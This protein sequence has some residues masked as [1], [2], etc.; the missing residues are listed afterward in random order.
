MA[1]V[2]LTYKGN[3]IAELND[4]G[5]KTIR[6]A[7]KFCEADIG[8][9]YV[10]PSG[11]EDVVKSYFTQ[12]TIVS[13]YGLSIPKCFMDSVR[14]RTVNLLNGYM[15]TWYNSQW[16]F[17]NMPNLE[18]LVL[19]K[20]TRVSDSVCGAS[21]PKLKVVDFPAVSV[22]F[23]AKVCNGAPALDTIILRGNSICVL[24]STNLFNA[25]GGHFA[26]GG[27]GGKIYIPKALYDHIGDGSNLD[28]TAA[29]NWSTICSRA[30]ITW[31]PIEGSE[32]DGVYADGTPIPTT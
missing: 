1:D 22:R 11:G 5:S 12:E 18:I 25:S 4:T 2:T 31:L 29:T 26:S 21:V 32:Y 27:T 13:D 10:K 16:A 23:E 24:A 15:D 28:Y 14:A 20:A 17:N 30:D 3:T 6:T 7:G 8:V 9:E 19:P